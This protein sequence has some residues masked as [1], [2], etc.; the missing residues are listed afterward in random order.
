VGTLEFDH[1]FISFI[2]QAS[3][4][5]RPQFPLTLMAL[6]LGSATVWVQPPLAVQAAPEQPVT[7]PVMPP[8]VKPTAKPAI[9]PTAKPSPKP[10]ATPTTKPV[11]RNIPA[12]EVLDKF[13]HYL[14]DSYSL[15]LGDSRGA[16]AYHV[17][18]AGIHANGDDRFFL[19][20]LSAGQVGTACRGIM[21]FRVMQADCKAQKLYEFVREKAED[22]R[23]ASW[24]R[25][26]STLW[27][28]AARPSADRT[29]VPEPAAVAQSQTA[30]TTICAQ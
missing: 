30:L 22:M 17:D 25:Y 28:P 9:K 23:N 21:V 18:P 13:Y 29:V 24:E 15:W 3:M 8:A 12:P 20:K 1:P 7:P 10:T 2:I 4:N 16:C 27:D 19:A 5:L 14:N 26:E 11:N 6:M